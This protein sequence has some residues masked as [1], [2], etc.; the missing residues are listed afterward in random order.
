M[1]SQKQRVL[2]LLKKQPVKN[3]EFFQMSP[4]ILS[5]A[6]VVHML[7][8]EGHDISIKKLGRGVFQYSLN[9]PVDYSKDNVYDAIGRTDLKPEQL[10][11]K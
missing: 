11:I 9:K 1:K 4:A 3:Y 2:D 7:R 8:K 6:A 10:E 5:G